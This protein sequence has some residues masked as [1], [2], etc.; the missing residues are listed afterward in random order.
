MPALKVI[1]L[2]GSDL[3]RSGLQQMLRNAGPSIEVTGIFGSL[4]ACKQLLPE[5]DQPH[6]LVLDDSLPG[7]QAPPKVVQDLRDAYPLLRII[8]LS[9]HLSAHYV[10]RLIE[11]GASGFLYREDQLE[12][13]LMA[14]IRAVMDGHVFVSSQVSALSFHRSDSG[15]SQTAL[16]VLR[17]MALGHTSQEIADRVGIACRSVYRICGGLRQHFDVRTNEHLMEVALRHGL[18]PAGRKTDRRSE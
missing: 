5:L 7:R 13:A 10:Q 17:L 6:A 16:E 4:H 3:V 9:S 12:I 15:L 1:V 18:L 2:S 11:C 14:G 8:V